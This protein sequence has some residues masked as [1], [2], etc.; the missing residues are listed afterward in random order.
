MDSEKQ[1]PKL[2][3]LGFFYYH[4]TMFRWAI[5]FREIRSNNSLDV[6]V[7]H[8]RHDQHQYIF[9]D[10]LIR[11]DNQSRT[12]WCAELESNL[13]GGKVV[14]HFHQELRVKANFN[15]LTFM[16]TR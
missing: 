8:N 15:V 14:E 16:L 11:R 9:V 10:A 12:V 13:L 6:I 5:S 3:G 7:K 1:N 4:D 2:M